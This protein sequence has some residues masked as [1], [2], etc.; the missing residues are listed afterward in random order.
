[1]DRM[2]NYYKYMMEAES[3]V[4]LRNPIYEA[5]YLQDAM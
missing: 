4:V 3:A 2:E 1:M 5:E